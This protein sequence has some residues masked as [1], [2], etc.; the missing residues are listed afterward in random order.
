[1]PGSSSARESPPG[2]AARS[3][4]PEEVKTT[5]MLFLGADW[6]VWVRIGR[7]SLVRR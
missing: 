7:R 3:M 1:M 4:I 5:R 6:A 2:G